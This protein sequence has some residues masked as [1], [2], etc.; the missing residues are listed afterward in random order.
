MG[1]RHTGDNT[2]GEGE[3]DD[4]T[5]I[6]DSDSLPR[7]SA[8]VVI[9][10]NSYTGETL[11]AVKH[12]FVRIWQQQSQ[13]AGGGAESKAGGANE[14]ASMQTVAHYGLSRVPMT[15]GLFFGVLSRAFVPMV[16]PLLGP[17]HSQWTFTTHA[18]PAKGKTA[19]LSLP[20]AIQR[21]QRPIMAAEGKTGDSGASPETNLA[22]I[23]VIA[24]R[25]L[26][27]A[28]G[29]LFTKK[30][31]DPYVVIRDVKGLDGDSRGTAVITKDLNPT[32]NEAFDFEFNYKLSGFV[33]EVFDYDK[34]SKDD[35]IGSLTLPLSLFY[36]G[37]LGAP[38]RVEG[39]YPLLLS[40]GKTKGELHVA[41]TVMWRIPAAI[42]G[43][44]I[45]LP[46]AQQFTVALGW[47]MK[48]GM[49]C[50]DLDAGMIVLD[51]DLV[52]RGEER[53][54]VGVGVRERQGRKERETRSTLLH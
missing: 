6:I 41:I 20:A 14:D 23:E 12:A 30:T 27:A 40:N 44:R 13:S 28:D 34:R 1:I 50:V 3:G 25:D 4:E 26:K 18:A 51:N 7:E 47:D 38:L 2:S 54:R 49:E 37:T 32:W 21:L 5:I 42:P 52:R 48:K 8:H 33:F 16:A 43:M 29:G 9:L 22:H 10:V 35:P 36:G 17:P 53:E 11:D 31:S 19:A 15:T 45:P 39:W 24:A 46:L